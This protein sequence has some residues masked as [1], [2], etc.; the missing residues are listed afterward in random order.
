MRTAE[1]IIH[2]DGGSYAVAYKEDGSWYELFFKIINPDAAR[3]EGITHRRPVLFMGTVNSGEIVQ[4]FNW[5]DCAAFLKTMEVTGRSEDV[6]E[7][8][9][10]H[11]T[12]DSDHTCPLSLRR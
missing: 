4:S 11:H 5:T 12:P 9:R 6:M 8:V 1:A 2:R 7:L 10:R 3:R